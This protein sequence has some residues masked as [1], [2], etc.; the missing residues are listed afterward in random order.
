MAPGG[1]CLE[2]AAE[3]THS[4]D[5]GGEGPRAPWKTHMCEA[6]PPPAQSL[7]DHGCLRKPLSLFSLAKRLTN[8]LGFETK[9]VN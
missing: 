5:G 7:P 6:S 9:Q 8:K 3:S 1:R 2:L 4:L